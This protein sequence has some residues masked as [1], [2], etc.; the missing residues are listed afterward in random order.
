MAN[1]D[2]IVGL[3]S[4]KIDVQRFQKQHWEGSFWD[5]LD[6]VAR[7]PAIARNSF[8]RLYDMVLHFG[9]ERYAVNRQEYTRYKFFSDPVDNGTDAIFGLDKALMNL[10]DFFRSAASQIVR[11]A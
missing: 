3:I 10:V 4:E 2:E 9:T 7:Q 8:Q 6:L 1:K 11:S 5:Y